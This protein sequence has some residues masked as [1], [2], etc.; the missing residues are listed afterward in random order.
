MTK[1]RVC[2]LCL[3]PLPERH[4]YVIAA[5]PQKREFC[6]DDCLDKAEFLE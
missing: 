3:G 2:W 4:A 5:D 6:S 1:A